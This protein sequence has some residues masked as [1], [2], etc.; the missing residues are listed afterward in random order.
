MFSGAMRFSVAAWAPGFTFPTSSLSAICPVF[1][2]A[3]LWNFAQTTL[4]AMEHKF[5]SVLKRRE[6]QSAHLGCGD[7]VCGSHFCVRLSSDHSRGNDTPRHAALSGFHLTASGPVNSGDSFAGFVRLR[8]GGSW[9][10]M[11]ICCTLESSSQKLGDPAFV[12]MLDPMNQIS[13]VC[14]AT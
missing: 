7:F 10:R 5:T 13:D 4:R 12:S 9:A 2:L 14:L 3:R 1:F 6:L 8:F 11:M